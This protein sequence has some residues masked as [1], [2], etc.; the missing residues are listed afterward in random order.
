MQIQLNDTHPAVAVPELMRL[1]MD[2]EE[3]E[4]DD[5]WAICQRVFAYTNHT[6]L[7]EALEAWDEGLFDACFHGTWD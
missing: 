6:V 4:W 3:L 1:L 2:E 7:P 5:A